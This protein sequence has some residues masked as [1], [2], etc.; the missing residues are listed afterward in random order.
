VAK[1][2]ASVAALEKARFLLPAGG[3]DLVKEAEGAPVP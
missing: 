3:A 1:V 2:K